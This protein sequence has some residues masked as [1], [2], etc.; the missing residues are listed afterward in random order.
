VKKEAALI[1]FFVL[2]TALAGM[3]SYSLGRGE[4]G[5]TGAAVA[6]IPKADF[7]TYTKAVCNEQE[8]GS[9]LCM[10]KLFAVCGGMEFQ[11]DSV[12]GSGALT[13]K[14]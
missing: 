6:G 3:F 5:A 12:N 7:Q 14:S 10:D 9:I 4:A 1:L 13:P 8:D 2:F 11:I